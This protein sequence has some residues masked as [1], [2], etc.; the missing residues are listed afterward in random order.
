MK[1]SNTS[2]TPVYTI[3][4]ASTAVSFDRLPGDELHANGNGNIETFTRM[5]CQKAEAVLEE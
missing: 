1:L 2:E 4:G 5:A 3:S